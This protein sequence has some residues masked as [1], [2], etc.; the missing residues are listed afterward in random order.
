MTISKKVLDELLSG[1]ETA[2]DLLCD[3]GLFKELKVWL[4]ERLLVT[5]L[6]QHLSYDPYAQPGLE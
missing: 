4:M 5:E 3:Q 1:V 2:D 6:T